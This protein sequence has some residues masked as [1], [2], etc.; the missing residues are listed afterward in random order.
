MKLHQLNDW[1]ISNCLYCKQP[2]PGK[3][4]YAG[5]LKAN[6]LQY[7]QTCLRCSKVT[8]IVTVDGALRV[9][10]PLRLALPTEHV[11]FRKQN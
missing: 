2:L 7:E 11:R 9:D 10:T 6:L 1:T 3:F 8:S 4:T 5:R